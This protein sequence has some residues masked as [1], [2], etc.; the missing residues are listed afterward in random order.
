MSPEPIKL[1]QPHQVRVFV[2]VGDDGKAVLSTREPIVRRVTGTKRRGL[3]CQPGDWMW[4]PG[5][6]MEGINYMLGFTPAPCDP[7]LCTMTIVPL[8]GE[9]DRA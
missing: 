8:P 1:N 5:Q 7:I 9:D 4:I 3:Y 6:C 2:T